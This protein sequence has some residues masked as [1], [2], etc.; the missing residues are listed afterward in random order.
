LPLE[1]AQGFLECGLTESGYQYVAV[2]FRGDSSYALA[3]SHLTEQE[4]GVRVLPAIYDPQV[5]FTL[6]MNCF[7]YVHGNSVGGTN[8]ALLE[9]MATCPRI[10][11][12]DVPFSREV[13]AGAGWY[14]T[15]GAIAAAFRQIAGQPEQ[16]GAYLRRAGWYDW[17]AVASAYMQIVDGKIPSYAGD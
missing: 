3:C 8:P 11:A 10:L 5:L 12:I 2:G 9:A 6:R 4:N 17:D 14:F 7:A 16:R 1:I 13:L 15:E